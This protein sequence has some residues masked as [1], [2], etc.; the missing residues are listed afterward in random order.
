MRIHVDR[1]YSAASHLTL[2]EASVQYFHVVI[3]F[4]HTF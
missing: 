1:N 2:E 3:L 4:E